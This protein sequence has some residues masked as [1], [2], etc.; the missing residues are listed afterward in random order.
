MLVIQIIGVRQAERYNAARKELNKR[1][2]YEL[3]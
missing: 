1:G 2:H 3:A